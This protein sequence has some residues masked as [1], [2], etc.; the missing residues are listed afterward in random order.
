M[1]IGTKGFTLLSEQRISLV[2]SMPLM[3]GISQS[4]KTMSG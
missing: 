1:M 4:V 2:M 3:S